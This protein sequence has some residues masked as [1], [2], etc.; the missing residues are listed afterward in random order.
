[1]KMVGTFEAK[2]QLSRL[3]DEVLAG[4]EVVITRRGKPEAILTAYPGEAK[5]DP[6]AA[7]AAM[8]A[9]KKKPLGA[10]SIKTLLEAGRR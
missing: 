6:R 4:E 9:F 3:I 1:M 2:T 10:L 8:Q 5:D 7:V